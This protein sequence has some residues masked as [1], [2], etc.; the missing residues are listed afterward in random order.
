MHICWGSSCDPAEPALRIQ[1]FHGLQSLW[2]RVCGKLS[3]IFHIASAESIA[4]SVI[5]N[6]N[7]QEVINTH[8]NL[9]FDLKSHNQNPQTLIPYY[10]IHQ[11]L[12]LHLYRINTQ[13]HT[14]SWLVQNSGNSLVAL[15]NMAFH[16]GH[17]FWDTSRECEW[18]IHGCSL[19]HSSLGM[20]WAWNLAISLKIS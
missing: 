15:A 4:W 11:I 1:M 18:S 19:S 8:Y 16:S 10:N 3:K 2:I 13:K 20:K 14:H 17:N 9:H 12:R 7:V 6:L 5:S